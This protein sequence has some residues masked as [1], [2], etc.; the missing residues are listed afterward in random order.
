MGPAES[1]FCIAVKGRKVLLSNWQVAGI[2][3]AMSGQ[4]MDIVDSAAGSFYFGA[5]SGLSPQSG[6]QERRETRR[7]QTSRLDTPSTH[8]LSFDPSYRPVK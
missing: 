4:P 3:T 2:I 5:N 7:P 6:Q 8:L 1:G